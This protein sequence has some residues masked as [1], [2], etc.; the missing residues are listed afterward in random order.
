[1]KEDERPRERRISQLRNMH[2]A[3]IQ[4]RKR[5]GIDGSAMNPMRVGGGGEWRE[6]APLDSFNIITLHY[7]SSLS[8]SLFLSLSSSFPA[9][10]GER[11]GEEEESYFPILPFPSIRGLLKFM[12]SPCTIPK[13]LLRPS[14]FYPK[15]LVLKTCQIYFLNKKYLYLKAPTISRLKKKKQ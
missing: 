13:Y 1:M 8:I 5:R 6:G 3:K 14:T 9:D 12:V 10:R 15:T 4:L 11:E 2:N 7:S